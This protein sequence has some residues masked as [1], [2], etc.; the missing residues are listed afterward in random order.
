MKKRI[1][2]ADDD[3]AI[4]D[5]LTMIL[6]DAGYA[7]ESTLDGKNVRELGGKLPDLILLDI[8]MAGMNGS[9]ICA[10]LKSK[11]TTER[12]P[13]ILVSANKDTEALAKA[14]GANSFILKPFDMKDLLRKVA[15]AVA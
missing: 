3:E 10:H 12:V 4:L 11:K 13:I 5:A 6:E 15:D 14:C 8:W 9:E 7:I 1:L 2:I